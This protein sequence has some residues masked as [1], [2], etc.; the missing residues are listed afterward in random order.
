MSIYNLINT[1]IECEIINK[2]NNYNYRLFK[3][4]LKKIDKNKTKKYKLSTLFHNLQSEYMCNILYHNYNIISKNNIICKDKINKIAKV[5][6]FIKEKFSF[7]TESDFHEI[8]TNTHYIDTI[9]N[10]EKLYVLKYSEVKNENINKLFNV[11]YWNKNSSKIDNLIFFNK[12]ENSEFY[13]KL[14][15]DHFYRVI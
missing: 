15:Y 5:K 14:K 7:D 10:V 4:K 11:E 8:Y 9:L 2:N 6:L 13:L 3:N 12:L 1:N